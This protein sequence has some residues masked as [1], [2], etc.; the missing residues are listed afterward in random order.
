MR[1]ELP[2]PPPGAIEM[3]RGHGE[4]AIGL[5]DQVE[6]DPLAAVRFERAAHRP[7]HSTACAAAGARPLRTCPA[8]STQ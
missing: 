2:G 7:E 3:V 5:A 6:R 4:D 1:C 8:E